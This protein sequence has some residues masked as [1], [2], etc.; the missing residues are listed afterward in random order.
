MRV[1]VYTKS[2]PEKGLVY[3]KHRHVHISGYSDSGYA[4]D[5]GDRKSIS[6]YCTFVGG[7]LVTWRR[8]KQDVSPSSAEVEY[9]VL[10]HTSCE[11]V[12]LK[13][14]LIELGFRQHE[15]MSMHCDNQSAICIAQNLV[16]HER[17]KHIEIDCH[18]VRDAWTKKV[19][20]FQFT[21]SLKQLADLFTKAASLQVFSNLCNK[22]SVL[23]VYAPT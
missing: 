18:F 6:G 20:M 16:F 13:N 5:R 15:P 7:K 9:R 10:A 4:G 11:M 19:V 3:R 23:D 17:T 12:W 8:K 2:C 1:L 22:L 21:P 14:S